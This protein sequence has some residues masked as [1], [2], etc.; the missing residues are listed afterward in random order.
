M[1]IQTET[2]DACLSPRPSGR[3]LRTWL[4]L[5]TVAGVLMTAASGV[6]S[7]SGDHAITLKTNQDQ[8][9]TLQ[10]SAALGI[11]EPVSAFKLVFSQL[12]DRV[13][14]YP[15][16]NYYYY[17]FTAGGLTY[18]GNIRLAAQ[19]RNQGIV[20][21]AIFRQANLATGS[22]EILY[23]ALSADD[24]VAVTKVSAFVYSITYDAK[25]VTFQLNDVSAVTPP[26]EITADGEEYLGAVFDESGIRF[27]LFYNRRL[28]LFA[29]VL[30]ET[31][32]VLDQFEP[33]SDRSRILIGAR[34]SFAL[35]DH[36]H[37]NRKVLIGVHDANTYVNNYF[38]GPADQL[39]ENHIKDDNLR[40]AIVHADPA[41]KGQLDTFGYLKSAE[42]R[43]LIAPYMQFQ[44]LDDLSGYE[45]CATDPD[46]T[47]AQ[48]DGC[49]HAGE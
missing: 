10:R 38:D 44:V 21:F 23:K 45:A 31:G 33:I 8:I 49:F 7:A 43:Y 46:V 37:L 1:S 24:G 6:V 39:P 36:H 4:S 29:Y 20:H 26:E 28:R 16:E 19:D 15:T 2:G 27:F 40:K 17:R 3:V 41:M 14:V 9:E 48:Y 22:G 47:K 42:G 18:A 34:T 13:F 35:Y 30:D 11:T 25:T 5:L 32:A 12:P